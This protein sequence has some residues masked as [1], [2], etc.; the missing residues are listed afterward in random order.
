MTDTRPSSS[1]HR[2]NA[3]RL[4]AL[5]A[6]LLV[7][8]ACQDQTETSTTGTTKEPTGTTNSGREGV[9]V[10]DVVGMSLDEA[11]KTLEAADVPFVVKAKISDEPPGTVVGQS[12][13]EGHRLFPGDFVYLFVSD[14]R[15]RCYEYAESC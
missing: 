7:T 10:P 15:P 9:E 11:R 2:R 3:L 6:A 13:R 12:P 14:E 5:A 8:T 4:V 1:R